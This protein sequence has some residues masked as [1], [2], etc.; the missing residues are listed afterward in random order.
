[1]CVRGNLNRN[2]VP[3]FGTDYGVLGFDDAERARWRG[4]AAVVCAARFE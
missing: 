2:G 1:M 3:V 4:I